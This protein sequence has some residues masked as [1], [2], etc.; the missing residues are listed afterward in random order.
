MES[1]AYAIGLRMLHLGLGVVD[2]I[3]G[4]EQ[5]VVVLVG[6][7]AKFGAAIGHDAQHRKIMFFMK[8]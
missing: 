1:L 6:P 5:L 7:T 2:I 4:Q 8:R 3:Y